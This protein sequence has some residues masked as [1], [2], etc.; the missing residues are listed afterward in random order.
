M[1]FL[2]ILLDVI[3]LFRFLLIKKYSVA[4][5]S[6]AHRQISPR[7]QPAAST[8]YPYTFHVGPLETSFVENYHFM[9]AHLSSKF[10]TLVVV[11]KHNRLEDLTLETLSPCSFLHETVP[12]P[13]HCHLYSSIDITV[14]PRFNTCNL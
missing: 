6:M 3:N 2:K 1:T 11:S 5:I 8:C 4:M 13:F 14:P 12:Y 7:H 10:P 9:W